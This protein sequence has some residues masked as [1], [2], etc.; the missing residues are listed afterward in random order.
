MTSNLLLLSFF[1]VFPPLFSI[2]LA[3]CTRRI[4]PSLLAGIL[5]GSGIYAYLEH[6]NFFEYSVSVF[7]LVL[8]NADHICIFLFS[9]LMGSFV[10]LIQRSGGVEGFLNFVLKRNIINTGRGAGFFAFATG[11]LLFL[12]GSLSILTVGTVARPLFRKYKIANEKLAYICDASCAPIAVLLP[13]NGWGAYLILQFSAQNIEEPV[14]LLLAS[15]PFFIYPMIAIVLCLLSIGYQWDI[16]FMHQCQEEAERECDA[17]VEAKQSP[18]ESE[19]QKAGRFWMPVC[20]LIFVAFL[21]MWVTGQG[22]IVAGNGSLSVLAAV[23]TAIIF[24]YVLY[25]TEHVFTIKALFKA[26]YD[27]MRDLSGIVLIL[28]LAFLLN[29]VCK[30]LQTGQ[31]L[32]GIINGEFPVFLLPMMIFILSAFMA[33][34]TGT[35]WGTF[36]IMLAMALPMAIEL[37]LYLPLIV[38][39]IVSGGVWGDHCSPVSDTTVLSALAGGSEVIRHV[40]SQ[41]P[42]AFIG[43]LLSA[44][45]FLILGLFILRIA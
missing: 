34:A 24:S 39:A 14:K 2:F 5:L 40:Q 8:L 38:G 21:S 19:N 1:S 29:A 18:G 33:F 44:V 41:L 4:I 37:K 42:Y 28:L 16:G 36:A 32:A 35:S 43:A 23:M 15:L 12:E 17:Y 9:L 27:G 22:N 31:T 13:L 10:C 11:T 30:D 6:V 45:I 20:V 26:T 25:L 3:L 7:L